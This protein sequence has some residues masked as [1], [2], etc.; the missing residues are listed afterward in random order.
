M[1]H[2]ETLG[3]CGRQFRE[4]LARTKFSDFKFEEFVSETINIFCSAS[5]KEVEKLRAWLIP[6]LCNQKM[7]PEICLYIVNYTGVG[8]IYDGPARVGNLRIE[9]LNKGV[10]CG[11]GEAH[12]FAYSKVEPKGF[13]I[14]A[15]PDV[16]CHQ[17][18]I[19]ELIRTRA[20]NAD[21]ALVEARQQPFEHP[22][23]FDEST[24]YT[25]WA[26]GFFLLID[27]GFF[28][29]AGGFDENFW[30][31]CEDVDLSWRAW[32][33]GFKVIHCSKAVGYHFTGTYFEY[34]ANR[35]YLENFWTARNFIYLSYKFWG[36][37]AE[38]KAIAKFLR[39]SYPANFKQEVMRS[40]E[41][42]KGNL[43]PRPPLIVGK[44]G[45]NLSDKVKITGFNLYHRERF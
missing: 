19:S 4:T 45:R 35:Y 28:T 27:S 44:I 39:R 23:E 15:N 9:E 41:E 24:G 42:M 29:Q 26:S 38:K 30:M 22:K 25:P 40:Y 1:N 36:N 11:F 7:A 10:A 43:P 13:F 6:S 5:S 12:N 8:K 3:R 2:W 33:N 31:Y 21:A 34:K 18:C 32:L 14:I 20:A 37:K 16:Y 17:S